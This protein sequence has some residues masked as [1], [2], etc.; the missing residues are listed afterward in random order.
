MTPCQAALDGSM[1]TRRS[2]YFGGFTATL[3]APS[4]EVLH[5]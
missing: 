1:Q 5:E 3:S 2:T 4:I